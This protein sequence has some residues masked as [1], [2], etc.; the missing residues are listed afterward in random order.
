[1]KM[2]PNLGNGRD[3]DSAPTPACVMNVAE[4]ALNCLQTALKLESW[5]FS[6]T[7]MPTA[8][9]TEHPTVNEQILTTLG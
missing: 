6:G 4:C 5:G 7:K 9:L 8:E 2:K 1:M 3:D